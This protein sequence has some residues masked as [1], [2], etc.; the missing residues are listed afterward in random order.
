M[1]ERVGFF[2]TLEH[3]LGDALV[4][5]HARRTNISRRQLIKGAG[6]GALVMISAGSWGAVTG[7]KRRQSDFSKLLQPTASRTERHT[8]PL[9]ATTTTPDTVPA[10]TT[11]TPIPPLKPLPRTELP[12][13]IK[14]GPE[15]NPRVALTIDDL[16]DGFALDNLEKVLKIAREKQV[17]L[18]LFPT[19]GALETHIALGRQ[20]V[21]RQTLAEGHE[22]GN[23]TYNHNIHLTRLSRE[24]IRDQLT[25]TQLKLNEALGYDYPMFM[26]RPP[27]GDGGLGKPNTKLMEVIGEQGMSMVMWT[28]DT[29]GAGH[30]Q[31]LFTE[32]ILGTGPE[33]AQNGS[34][35]LSHFNTYNS[36]NFPG[37]IDRLRAERGLEPTSISG[38]FAE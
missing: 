22:I 10:T 18:S 9:R 27:G 15:D 25:L 24:D 29:N 12:P 19:G 26:M 21:W 2:D 28:T 20:A 16:F 23:H 36:D 3:Q 30:G 34:I 32:K 5:E 33:A 4:A 13:Y 1:T 38:M 14:N 6:A 31:E 37:L 7:G 8:R 35:I 17:R 11:T